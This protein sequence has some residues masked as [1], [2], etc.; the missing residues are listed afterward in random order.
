MIIKDRVLLEWFHYS[1]GPCWLS[2]LHIVVCIFY[3]QTPNLSLSPRIFTF[4]LLLLHV[5]VSKDGLNPSIESICVHVFSRSWRM[6]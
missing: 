4:N 6:I 1:V 3:S 5:T 2:V